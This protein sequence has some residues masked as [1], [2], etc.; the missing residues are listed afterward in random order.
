MPF[1]VDLE[2]PY[3][4]ISIGYGII[5]LIYLVYT[6]TRKDPMDDTIKTLQKKLDEIDDHL[7]E[8]KG[9]LE[10]AQMF[11]EQEGIPPVLT[12]KSVLYTIH[13]ACKEDVLPYTH[14]LDRKA[15]SD[16]GVMKLLD[17]M[18]IGFQNKESFDLSQTIL[19]LDEFENVLYVKENVTFKIEQKNGET[20]KGFGVLILTLHEVLFIPMKWEFLK[21]LDRGKLFDLLH[22]TTSSVPFLNVGLATSELFLAYRDSQKPA[23]IYFSTVRKT[24]MKEHYEKNGGWRIP[25]DKIDEMIFP[26]KMRGL[27]GVDHSLYIE[28]NRMKYQLYQIDDMENFKIELLEQMLISTLLYKNIYYPINKKYDGHF[29]KCDLVPHTEIDYDDPRMVEFRENEI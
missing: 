22:Q 12:L 18:L 14:A 3:G 9:I 20:K 17:Q 4:A 15:P 13:E 27:K 29:H 2:K 10:V 25:Y 7:D 26:Y 24:E 28:T 19:E 6:R 21:N 5:A 23:E 8:G 11:Q 1:I 16:I